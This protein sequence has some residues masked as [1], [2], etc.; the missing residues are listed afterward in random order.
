MKQKIIGCMVTWGVFV[1]NN[2]F[3]RAKVDSVIGHLLIQKQN[4]HIKIFHAEYRL[5]F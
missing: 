1:G 4:M 2:A 5:H 3:G